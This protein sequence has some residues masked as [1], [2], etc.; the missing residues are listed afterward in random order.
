MQQF[1][2]YDAISAVLSVSRKRKKTRAPCGCAGRFK[3]EG[4]TSDPGGLCCPVLRGA[5]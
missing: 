5:A 1:S 2:L 3:P 4:L